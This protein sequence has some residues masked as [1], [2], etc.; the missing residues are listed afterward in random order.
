MLVTSSKVYKTAPPRVRRENE[1]EDDDE[2][3]FEAQHNLEPT[4]SLSSY[5]NFY[6]IGEII[7]LQDAV[8][9]SLRQLTVERQPILR[10]GDS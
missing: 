2:R 7:I 3:P 5:E 6:N 9:G 1:I 4:A 8:I 10:V